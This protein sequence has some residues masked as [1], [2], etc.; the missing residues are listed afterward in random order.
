MNWPYVRRRVPFRERYFFRP[1]RETDA[2]RVRV[3]GSAPRVPARPPAYSAGA[4]DVLTKRKCNHRAGR[5]G[6][7]E[8]RKRGII[9]T[10]RAVPTHSFRAIPGTA[11]V[12][13]SAE[14]KTKKKEKGKQI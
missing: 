12:S 14:H 3:T 10:D 7:T 5:G 13:C 8:S 1:F 9:F 4:S 6:G 11:T 2:S